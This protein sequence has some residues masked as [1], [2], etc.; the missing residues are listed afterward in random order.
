[1]TPSSSKGGV[2]SEETVATLKEAV[3]EREEEAAGAEEALAEALECGPCARVAAWLV[4]ALLRWRSRG[5]TRRGA[6]EEGYDRIG[7]DKGGKQETVSADELECSAL[8]PLPLL[9]LG[10]VALPVA[11]RPVAAPRP[12]PPDVVLHLGGFAVQN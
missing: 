5:A 9:L 1:M 7:A 6:A 10:G 8:E 2:D 4:R 3:R 12:A 11:Q